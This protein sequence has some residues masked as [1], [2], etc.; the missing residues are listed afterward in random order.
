MPTEVEI[1]EAMLARARAAAQNAGAAGSLGHD[2]PIG[3]DDGASQPLEAPMYSWIAPKPYRHRARHRV[4]VKTIEGT[5]QFRMF[6][7]EA[8]AM[9]FIARA[10]LLLVKDGRPIED[11]ITGYLASLT[12][13][14]PV[15]LATL[16]YRL[17]AVTK[18]RQR[19][20]I[21]FFPWSLAWKQNVTTQAR[22]SQIGIL[23]ALHGLI[24][25][26][27]LRGE[28]LRGLVPAGPVKAGK[29][30]LHVDEA[31][32]FV[33]EAL[34]AGDPLALA[35]ATM[36]FCGL[37]PGEVLALVARDVDDGGALLH[38]YGTKT[39][40][41]RRPI[42][43]DPA[44]QPHLLEATR[45]KAAGDLLFDFERSRKRTNQDPA[46]SRKDALLRRVRHLCKVARVPE[47][48]PHSLRG[49][50]ATLR[51]MGGATDESITR[52]L[53][54]LDIS[55]TRRHYFA[56]GVAEQIDAK[57]AHGRLLRP[58]AA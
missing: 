14:K 23:T 22:A 43:V 36:A 33:T 53:G 5:R 30:S 24:R 1:L 46:K 19:I 39:R 56:P 29:P 12:D 58:R 11:M 49:L 44:F 3:Q 15:S 4:W 52:A 34:Q 8:E 57:R 16:R 9:A 20:P 37:R 40:A 17:Q 28:P 26:A 18:G 55:T 50:N 42:A 2:T 54:H 45:G 41:A 21:E 48:V 13:H 27:K 32:L 7:T 38:V 47:I 35:A 31:R 10:K 25:F 6:D 51:L